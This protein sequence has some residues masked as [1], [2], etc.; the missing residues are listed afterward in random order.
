MI[1]K[2]NFNERL[3][4]SLKCT[5]KN[6]RRSR[7]YKN[8]ANN[9]RTNQSKII[10]DLYLYFKKLTP[11]FIRQLHLATCPIDFKLLLIYI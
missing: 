5:K 2:T 11:N 1:L 10:L 7:T 9:D 4:T 8:N 3:N 6:S